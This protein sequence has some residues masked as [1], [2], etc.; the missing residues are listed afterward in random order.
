MKTLTK[1]LIILLILG[2]VGYGVYWYFSKKESG[3]TNPF[4]DGISIGDFFPFGTGGNVVVD[5][6][7][8]NNT[9]NTPTDNQSPVTPPQLWQISSEPQSGAV[10]FSAS[11]T[12]FVRFVDKATG[13]IIESNLTF[14]GT[15]RISNTTIPKIYR[16]AWQNDGKSLVMQYLGT[17]KET[18]RTVSAKLGATASS[19]E[20]SFRELKTTFLPEGIANVSIDPQ[21]NTLAYLSESQAGSKVFVST[22]KGPKQIFDSIIKDFT[23]SWVNKNTIALMSKPSAV[24]SGQF[25]FLKSDNGVLSR[26]VSGPFGLTALA[27]PSATQVFY[28]EITQS[29]LKTNTFDIKT[30]ATN[31]LNLKT[32]ADKCVWS[33]K[34]A[35]ILYCAV[36]RNLPGGTY[37]DDWYMG[38]VNFD[39]N[40]WQIDTLSG[41]TKLVF[42][43]NTT[44]THLD[45][46]NLAL[47][48]TEHYLVFTN[49]TDSK[50]WGLKIQ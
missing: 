11:S 4:S 35:T 28:S 42:D 37:P 20:G 24:A 34:T 32:F 12:P 43:P 45:A 48:P 13:N 10:V 8:Q 9:G 27:N 25:Y 17:D 26:V 22:A 33:N 3:T 7:P 2:I 49:K 29:G 39:D 19:S 6:T 23:I 46:I 41:T 30:G 15:K 21:T 47:D 5:N 1:I 36:P 38:K 44:N 50:L 31:P 14:T 18:V 40:I 16:T